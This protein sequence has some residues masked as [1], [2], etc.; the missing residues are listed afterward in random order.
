MYYGNLIDYPLGV[1]RI[2][3]FASYKPQKRSMRSMSI[4][5]LLLLISSND[6]IIHKEAL[7]KMLAIVSKI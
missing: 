5:F 4:R 6:I 1:G 7:I 2:D 3:F